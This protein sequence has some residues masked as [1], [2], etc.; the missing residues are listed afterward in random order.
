[1]S[2]DLHNAIIKAPPTALDSLKNS[3]AQLQ[4]KVD[5]LQRI[6]ERAEI[7]GEFFS[8]VISQDLYMFS[9]IV[10]V[11]GLVSWSF[12]VGVLALHK[13]KID[14]NLKLLISEQE[15]NN[16]EKNKVLVKDLTDTIYDVNRAMYKLTAADN[17]HEN[18]FDWALDLTTT[19][20]KAK[21]SDMEL[22][23]KFWVEM[24]L[25][26]LSFIEIGT[27][28][29]IDKLEANIEHLDTLKDS[30]ITGIDDAILE[31]RSSLYIKAYSKP[32]PPENIM[33]DL[34]EVLPKSPTESPTTT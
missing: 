25:Y 5:S 26:H 32:Q 18:A 21:N 28:N 1:M 17:D 13:R 14:R 31:I 6:S 2:L 23:I 12:V 24:A 11:A 19:S 16:L 4:V 10:I 15:E 20:L 3:M 33:E 27:K 8:D 30:K 29:L 22:D 34:N 9:T 7:R